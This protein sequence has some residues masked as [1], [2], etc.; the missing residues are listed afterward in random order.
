MPDMDGR[1]TYQALR[2]IPGL[3]DAPMIFLTAKVQPAELQ[4]L[5][6]L[7]A[8]DVIAKPFEALSLPD[9]LLSLLQQ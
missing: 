2:A 9:R 1:A 6:R 3:A 8:V 4:E 7:G 5:F